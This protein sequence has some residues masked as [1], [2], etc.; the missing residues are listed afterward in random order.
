MTELFRT[1]T[2]L[3]LQTWKFVVVPKS[4]EDLCAC[5]L[6]ERIVLLR[7][8][9]W[10][11]RHGVER[12]PITHLKTPSNIETQTQRMHWVISGVNLRFLRTPVKQRLK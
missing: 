7:K 2:H 10:Y 4:A 9:K 1:K 3:C 12:D 11:V 5:Y 8:F 6:E